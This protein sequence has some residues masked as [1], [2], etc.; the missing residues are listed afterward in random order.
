MNY[1]LLTLAALGVCDFCVGA[2]NNEEAR[3]ATR[4]SVEVRKVIRQYALT[5]ANDFPQRDP[6]DWQLLGSNDGGT[7]WVTLDVRQ[8]ELFTERHQRR[9]FRLNNQTAFNLYRLQIDRVANPEQADSVQVAEIEPL[10]KNGDDL[11][12]VPS[13]T[14]S[15]TAQGQNP[16]SETARLAFDG[17]VETKWLDYAV[18]NRETRSSWIQW[19]YCSATNLV[20]TSIAGLQALRARAGMGYKTQIEGVIAGRLADGNSACFLDASGCLA[21]RG[22]DGETS[23]SPGERVLLEGISQWTNSQA[24]IAEPRLVPRGPK[25]P[26]EP[27]R[28]ELE[29]PMTPDQDL[30]WVETEGIVRFS[31]WAEDRLVFELEQNDR[32][33]SVNVFQADESQPAR[34]DGVRVRVRGICRNLVN[35][36]GE[37][38]ASTL[39]L[40]N[41]ESL[42]IVARA[43]GTANLVAGATEENLP[44]DANGGL[45]TEIGQI[46]RL[47]PEQL[48]LGRKVK[49]RGIVTELF[50]TC[51]QDDTGGIEVNVNPMAPQQQTLG[52]YI[53][54]EGLGSWEIGH[55]PIL[56]PNRIVVL[57]KGKL[58]RAQFASYS[59]LASGKG[60][61]QWVDTE[62]VVRSTDGSHLLLNC[63]GQE[64]MAT[65]RR[66]PA[67]T[68]E[69][70]VDATIRVRGVAITA[71]DDRGRVQGI[72]LVIP[73]LEDVDIEKPAEDPFALPIH[74]IGGLLDLADT[75]K[76]VHRVRI[77]GVLTLKEDQKYFVQDPTG[78]AV[79]L[80][81]QEVVLNSRDG[82]A[83]WVF[84]RS[85]TRISLLQD[86]RLALGDKVDIVGF[87]EMRGYSLLLTEALVRKIERAGNV[88]AVKTDVREISS[89]KFDATLVSLDALC[90]REDLLGS[91]L[92]LMLQSGQTMFR[93][94]LPTNQPISSAVAPGSHVQVTGVCEMESVPYAE[95]GKSVP[96]FTLMLRS[97]DDVTLL[98]RPSWWTLKRTLTLSAA[99]VVMLAIT[100]AWIRMLRSQVGE[101]TKQLEEEIEEHKQTEHNLAEKSE[102]LEAEIEE[103]KVVQSELEE[104]RTILEKEI[105]ERKR[106]QTEVYRVQ[107]QLIG[108]SRL[109]GMAEVAT[110][111]LHNVGNVLNSANIFTDLIA[112]RVRSSKARS[113]SR[114]ADL[115]AEQNGKLEEFM[116]SD[117]RG[118][119]IPGYLALLGKHLSEEQTHLLGQVESL[120][121]SISHVKEVV[122]RQQDYAKVAGILE[123]VAAA[124]VVNDALLMLRQATER[125]HVEI[126]ADYEPAPPINVDRHKVLQILFNL[127]ENALQAC[128]EN[129]RRDKQIRV[130]IRRLGEQRISISVLD[131]GIGIPPENFKRIFAQGFSTRRGGHGFGLHSSILMA[132]DMGGSL[133]AQSDGAGAGAVFILELP[134]GAKQGS[135]EECNGNFTAE[136]VQAFQR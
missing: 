63:D 133:V 16:P 24:Q 115:L 23:F 31:A 135:D 77:E 61:D 84:W 33:M 130:R 57:G 47:S 101:R 38:V 93:G 83:N 125:R 71:S 76:L 65:I 82:E 15:V 119:R 91:H 129:D 50:G 118:K 1:V 49:I 136:R 107:G 45:L 34:L 14:D 48:I 64:L 122:A 44:T 81:K 27:R 103:R 72:H 109:A 12:P 58:P 97:A 121:E 127:L 46:R 20:I 111:I 3:G 8:G 17:Q 6:Q 43:N 30:E 98:E 35:A 25:P 59:L 11:D 4:S 56:R 94:F 78:S 89:G 69:G 124:D 10:G 42:T 28:I 134:T 113:V 74:K 55:G 32:T 13:F 86:Q 106:M 88:Q 99:L 18:A 108:A 53:E 75:T 40:P 112:D 52:D 70:L 51:V 100:A 116:A 39:W 66:A 131:N 26:A 19:Q 60:V 117:D 54:V 90:M 79:A 41:L 87:P 105:E 37:S 29:Q 68:V 104:K 96:S 132:Q 73:S 36:R 114:L 9:I 80:P 120:K 21:V 95:L 126:I 2:A 85:P 102:L 22:A 110:S 5:S 123:T 92:V 128:H 7:S 67:P 62:A